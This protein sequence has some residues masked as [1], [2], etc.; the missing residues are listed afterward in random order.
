MDIQNL[1]PLELAVLEDLYGSSEITH[2]LSSDY[3][4][5]KFNEWCSKMEEDY[6]ENKL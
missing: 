2:I 5:Q 6:N 4:T 3:Y 1:N